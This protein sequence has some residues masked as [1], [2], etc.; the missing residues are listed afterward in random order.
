MEDE[1]PTKET[2]AASKRYAGKLTKSMVEP[3]P[4]LKFFKSK[5]EDEDGLSLRDR[6]TAIDD[7]PQ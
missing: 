2:K 3:R 4:F 6:K 1:S 5:S 7:E